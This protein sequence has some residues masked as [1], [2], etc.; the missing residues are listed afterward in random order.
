MSKSHN[1]CNYDPTVSFFEL[2]LNP[3]NTP[4]IS[5][6]AVRR[7]QLPHLFD[8][9]ARTLSGC[10]TSAS[11]KRC[12]EN[13]QVTRFSHNFLS[14]PSVLIQNSGTVC[15]CVLSSLESSYST[16]SVVEA[17]FTSEEIFRSCVPVSSRFSPCCV[18]NTSNAMQ[19]TSTL[20]WIRSEWFKAFPL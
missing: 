17:L 3:Q 1:N 12:Q 2:K 19:L 13:V 15:R 20:T 5:P 6:A 14:S 18:L 8:N 10:S 16:C 11:S 4:L 7:F 9:G